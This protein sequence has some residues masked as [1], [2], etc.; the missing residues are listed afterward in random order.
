[1]YVLHCKSQLVFQRSI[2][3]V[4]R[5]VDPVEAGMA[6]WKLRGIARLLDSESAGAIRTLQ[7]LE[8]VDR[9]S[10]GSSSELEQAGFTFG[11]P[12]SNALPKPLD[13]LVTHL[14]SS[15]VR[16]LAPVVTDRC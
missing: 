10:G 6:L 9:D 16:E 15:V 5:Q 7:I 14:I 13:D 4:R 11:R 1:M 2:V 8:P 12:A 3:L